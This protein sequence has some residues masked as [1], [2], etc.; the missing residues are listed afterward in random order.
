MLISS[1]VL[2]I[3][4]LS[5]AQFDLVKIHS[6]F[7]YFVYKVK[8]IQ[9]TFTRF[10]VGSTLFDPYLRVMQVTRARVLKI[11]YGCLLWFRMQSLFGPSS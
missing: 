7:F 2:A 8:Y 11:G 4:N 3:L 6:A 1:D 9:Y 5:P 10:H